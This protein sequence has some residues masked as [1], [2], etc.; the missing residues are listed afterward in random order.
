MNAIYKRYFVFTPCRR[1]F[2]TADDFIQ[3]CTGKAD[4]TKIIVSLMCH[5]Y[6]SG[7]RKTVVLQAI[8]DSLAKVNEKYSQNPN[9]VSQDQLNNS[10]QESAAPKLWCANQT[11]T[12]AKLHEQLS[13]N[14]GVYLNLIDEIEGLFEALDNK[15]R[16]DLMDRRMWLSLNSGSSWGRS[17]NKGFRDVPETR[18]N[19][20]GE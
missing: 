17:T 5:G 1:Y 20:T 11:I 13:N 18:L 14:D 4:M 10:M 7:S 15:N 16:P 6:Y 2:Q 12:M 19:Y 9:A 8:A 3:R